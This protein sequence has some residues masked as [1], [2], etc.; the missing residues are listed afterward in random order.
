MPAFF[1]MLA[2]LVSG[3]RLAMLTIVADDGRPRTRPMKTLPARCN[4][5]HLWL[6]AD[7]Y[8][9]V[10]DIGR[11]AEVSLVYGSLETGRC[12]TVYGS[13]IV[14]KTS[15]AATSTAQESSASDRSK[16]LVCVT[17]RAAEF[18]DLNE[19]AMPQRLE[20]PHPQP[21]SAAVAS[22]MLAAPE[23]RTPRLRLVAL[24]PAL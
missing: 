23:R 9:I 13:A 19:S 14:L 6:R 21:I 8:D 1:E 12:V 4:D 20:P 24:E 2:P 7:S 16:P 17:A 5:H 11:G 15:L 18:W 22:D 10:R 3:F